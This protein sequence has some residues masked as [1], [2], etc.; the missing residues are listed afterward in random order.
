MIRLKFWQPTLMPEE[1]AAEEEIWRPYAA[2]LRILPTPPRP[3]DFFLSEAQASALRP[4]PIT[5]TRG[6]R[7][8]AT[9]PAVL[10]VAV[11]LLV[12]GQYLM[13]TGDNQTANFS[14]SSGQTTDQKN[15]GGAV[16]AAIMTAAPANL[17]PQSPQESCPAAIVLHSAASVLPSPTPS[18][19]SSLAITDT[20]QATNNC[21]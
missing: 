16:P 4:A 2:A 20:A 17:G 12:G 10:V 14:N 15:A 19:T 9:L 3:R 21:P 11:T 8:G 13:Q 5:A 7:R 6:L 1:L 18:P